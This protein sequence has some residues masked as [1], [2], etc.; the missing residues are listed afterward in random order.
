MSLADLLARGR[1]AHLRGTARADEPKDT[2]DEPIEEERLEDGDESE[3]SE[4]QA[5]ARWARLAEEDPEREQGEDESDDDYAARMRRLDEQE[6]DAS[7]LD[8]VDDEDKAKK[9]ARRAGRKAAMRR[10]A[11]IFASPA[12]AK[13]PDIAAELAFG[14]DLSARRAISTLEKAVARI[15]A[16]QTLAQRMQTVAPIPNPGSEAAGARVDPASPRGMAQ[17]AIAAA[18]KAR[19]E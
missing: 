18:R 10:C 3:E 14:S 2:T 13:A 11:A 5:R 7:D 17:A 8:G 19:G 6:D 9:A 15:P 16:R 1:F 12:A 4:A